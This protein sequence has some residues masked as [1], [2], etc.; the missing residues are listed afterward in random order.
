MKI[1]FIGDIVGKS[2]RQIV[3]KYLPDLIKNIKLILLSL[4]GKTLRMGR[5]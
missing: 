4:M 5:V 1:L 3:G 2:G